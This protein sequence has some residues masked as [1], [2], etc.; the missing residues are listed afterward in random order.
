MI[1]I[2]IDSE[3]KGPNIIELA[4]T[5]SEIT[6]KTIKLSW[7]NSKDEIYTLAQFNRNFTLHVPDIHVFDRTVATFGK[8]L[9][10]SSGILERAK[11]VLTDKKGYDWRNFTGE[12]RETSAKYVLLKLAADAI[13]RGNQPSLA[14]IIGKVLTDGISSTDADILIRLRSA[15]M[16]G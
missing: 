13:R 7:A 15:R 4:S 1:D 8:R 9:K 2:I 11:L 14:E 3:Y 10:I 12:L 6:D 5:I 16:R